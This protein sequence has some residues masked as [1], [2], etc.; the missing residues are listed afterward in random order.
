MESK[1]STI[2]IATQVVARPQGH[3]MV[4]LVPTI[5]AQPYT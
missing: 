5:T 4:P 3:L 1:T 2:P